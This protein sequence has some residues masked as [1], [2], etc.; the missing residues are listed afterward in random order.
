[1]KKGLSFAIQV[2]NILLFLSLSAAF[3][4]AGTWADNFDG[5][6]LGLQWR[7]DRDNFSIQ[8][9]ALRG[10]NAHP[11]MLFP[12]RW[13]EVGKDWDDYVVQCRINVV[14]P[15]LLVCTKGA[16]ILRHS[17]GEGYIFALHVANGTVEIYR[18]SS[19]E[20]L[21]SK[22]VPLELK[23]W[24]LVRAE[25]Q[26]DNLSFYLNNNLVGKL[27]DKDS[28]SGAVGLGVQDALEVLFD[29]FT[30]IG[31]KVEPE[32]AMIAIK[33]KIAT[34]WALIRAGNYDPRY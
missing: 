11:I 14:T 22:A 30:V 26:G 20:M 32:S 33:K 25:L 29:D 23:T 17:K 34:A 8:D 16:L 10:V 9:G 4:F 31:P 1:M 28:A 6:K 21:L 13:V 2:S 19:G 7:G 5:A 12:L 18:L 27:V 24:Y 15:N 3:S